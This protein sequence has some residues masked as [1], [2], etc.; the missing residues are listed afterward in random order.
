MNKTPFRFFLKWIPA[1]A[2]ITIAATALAQF[3]PHPELDWFTIETP[4]FY[5]HYHKGEE[6]SA[7]TVAKIAE[8]VYGPI[9]SLYK[10]EPSEKVSFVISDVSDYGNGAT[11]YYGNRIEIY[12]TTLDVDFRVRGTRN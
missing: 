6:R 11:D 12:A 7:N 3:D 9:T 8:E 1:F 10:Y 4:H 5:V 2:G